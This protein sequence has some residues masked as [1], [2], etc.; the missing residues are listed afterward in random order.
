MA[1]PAPLGLMGFAMTMFV[2]SFHNA[3]LM[4]PQSAPHWIVTGLDAIYGG[5]LQRLA[6]MCEFRAT[7]AFEA[8]A[9]S[10][11]ICLLAILHLDFDPFFGV[12]GAF[13]QNRPKA[14]ISSKHRKIPY[15]RVAAAL[16]AMTLLLK[17]KRRIWAE[18]LQTR[19]DSC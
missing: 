2:L 4:I 18:W 3:G 11:Y 12:P 9:F 6:R 5:L 19:I 7:N 14:K 8:T 16:A 13:V 17:V 10:S 15:S 1:N